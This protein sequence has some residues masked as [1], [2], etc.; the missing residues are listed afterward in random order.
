M[1][2]C[3]MAS[4]PLVVFNTPLETLGFTA[5][6]SSGYH[7][8]TNGQTERA[9]QDLEK[10]E[11]AVSGKRYRLPCSTPRPVNQRLTE[12][13]RNPAQ[14]FQQDKRNGCLSPPATLPQRPPL[15]TCLS[16]AIKAQRPQQRISDSRA[17]GYRSPCYQKARQWLLI[18]IPSVLVFGVCIGVVQILAL[19]FSMMMYYQ[20]LCAEKHLD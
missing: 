9:Y 20:I 8:Q 14:G 5:S 12:R 13:T 3:Q 2:V 7:Q 6:L 4:P 10:E 17:G 19:G 15:S 11:V 18:N 16:P 1:P